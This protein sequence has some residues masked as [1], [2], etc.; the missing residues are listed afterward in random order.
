MKFPK[1]SPFAQLAIH[2]MCDAN[3]Q[4]LYQDWSDALDE[5]EIPFEYLNLENKPLPPF[6]FF[7]RVSTFRNLPEL[8]AQGQYLY[9]RESPSDLKLVCDELRALGIEHYAFVAGT[10]SCSR[11][12]AHEWDELDFV[13]W[14]PELDHMNKD[15]RPLES[16]GAY[17][18]P[19]DPDVII[20]IPV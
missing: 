1:L 7:T 9:L 20:E 10:D 13:L 16:S 3:L 17:Y 14:V 6:R 8:Y 18:G 2:T 11:D 12:D 4:A 5:L 15:L 19:K